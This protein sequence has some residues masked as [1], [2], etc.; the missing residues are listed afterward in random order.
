MEKRKWLEA[1]A[2]SAMMLALILDS[3]TAFSGAAQ[4]VEL[5]LKTVIPSLFPFLFLSG[6]FSAAFSGG[7]LP[8]LRFLGQ[9]FALP[10]KMEYLLVPAFLGGYPVGAQCV[11]DAYASGCLSRRKAEKMLAFCSN[12][13]PAFLFGILSSQFQRINLVW[14]IWGIQIL[15]AW[16]AARLLAD[17]EAGN[18][19]PGK[20]RNP[21]QAGI[22][23]A[24]QAMLKICGWIIL[25]RVVIAFL[26]RW[27][28]W[29]VSADGRIAIIGLLELSNGCCCL[30]LISREGVRFVIC[31]VLLAFGGLC[32]AYQTASVCRGLKLRYYFAGKILQGCTAAFLAAAFYYQRWALFPVWAAATLAV[33]KCLQKNSRNPALLG[34]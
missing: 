2:A 21:P 27:I 26:D 11:S 12:V 19:S 22:E 3:R 5:C 6:I 33:S 13:G 32:V 15:S 16:T 30:N 18:E 17:P 25:F 20:V 28:L 14:A 31:N 29:A 34:V 10:P 8:R 4:G 9:A 23:P 7:S 1:A 24:I